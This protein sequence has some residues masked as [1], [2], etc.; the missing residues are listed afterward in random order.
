MNHNFFGEN[1]FKYSGTSNAQKFR[2]DYLKII[3]LF[4]FSAVPFAF[5]LFYYIL[6]GSNLPNSGVMPGFRLFL[7]FL[8]YYGFFSTL[9]TI[10]LWLFAHFRRMRFIRNREGKV[11]NN[12]AMELFLVGVLTIP[13]LALAVGLYFAF[14]KDTE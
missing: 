11:L 2:S 9:S 14:K 4:I 5:G 8:I 3:F 6:T 13:V 7:I 10:I 1:F 12:F